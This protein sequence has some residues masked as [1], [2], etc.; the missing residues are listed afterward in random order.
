MPLLSSW[1]SVDLKESR[2]YHLS[3]DDKTKYYTNSTYE[4][5]F[6]TDDVCGISNFAAITLPYSFS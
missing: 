4:I 1:T 6:F 2:L 3:V 5:D